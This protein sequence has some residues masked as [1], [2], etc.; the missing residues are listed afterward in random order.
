MTLE[1]AHALHGWAKV[2]GEVLIDLAAGAQKPTTK[3]QKPT[4]AKA[5]AT[6]GA[7][8]KPREKPAESAGPSA[9]DSQCPNG[10]F[11]PVSAAAGVEADDDGACSPVMV[12]AEDKKEK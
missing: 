1:D 4:P 10:L 3:K 11:A 6:A 5:S 8:D 7:A 9:A 2:Q 12:E